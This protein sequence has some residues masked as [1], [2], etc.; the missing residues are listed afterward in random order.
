MP[1]EL[2]VLS[3]Q[4]NPPCTQSFLKAALCSWSP[5]GGMQAT[6]SYASYEALS[7]PQGC[8]PESLSLLS[9][10][11]KKWQATLNDHPGP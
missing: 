1:P 9:I 4:H 10:P 11:M 3:L 7:T 5:R 6:V 2:T 8:D